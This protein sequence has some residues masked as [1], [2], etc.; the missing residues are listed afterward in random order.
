MC[1][2]VRCTVCGKTSWDGCGH[3]VDSVM[4]AVPPA[5]R[6]TC[7]PGAERPKPRATPFN[8]RGRGKRLL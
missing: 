7:S 2:P 3:H 1:Y 5:Q 6:C 8:R 4:N